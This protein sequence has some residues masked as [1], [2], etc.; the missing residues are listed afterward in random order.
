MACVFGLWKF[1]ATRNTEKH[2]HPHTQNQGGEEREEE[3]ERTGEEWGGV[4][5]KGE[6]AGESRGQANRPSTELQSPARLESCKEG[7][8]GGKGAGD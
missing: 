3:K 6:M 7:R 4:A 2:E 1:N 5:C 8:E